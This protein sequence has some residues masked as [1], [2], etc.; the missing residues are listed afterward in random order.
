MTQRNPGSR[1]V[2]EQRPPTTRLTRYVLSGDSYWLAGSLTTAKD[3]FEEAG[4]SVGLEAATIR[5]WVHEI[6]DS[7]RAAPPRVALIHNDL[8]ANHVLV[9]NG[10]VSG[11]IDF[12]EVAAEPAASDF[13]GWDFNEGERFPVAWIRAG[14]RDH[15]LFEAPNDRTYRALRLA[16][17]LW[18]MQWYHGTGFQSGVQAARDRLLSETGR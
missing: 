10:K 3:G 8:L 11:I 7:F 5:G 9:H 12:G 14:Y 13:A 17:G 18:L 16:T 4:R 6:V 15:S 2:F 1:R